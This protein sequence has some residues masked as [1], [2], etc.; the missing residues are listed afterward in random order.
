[1]KWWQ[2]H[3]L[4]KNMLPGHLE[5]FNFPAWLKAGINQIIFQTSTD[6]A[7][8]NVGVQT[9]GGGQY[10]DLP[11]ILHSRRI[12]TFGGNAAQRFPESLGHSLLSPVLRDQFNTAQR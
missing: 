9:Y 1:M 3:P 12:G 7:V 2:P 10:V 11:P 5:R 4:S 6:M 8:F